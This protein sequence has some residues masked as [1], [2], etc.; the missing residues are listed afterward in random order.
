MKT[1]KI[2]EEVR[3]G[4]TLM[5]VLLV[6]AILGVIAAMAVP[7]LITT[8]GSSNI[9]AAKLSITGIESALNFYHTDHIG[10]FPEGQ[11]QGTLGILTLQEESNGQL[12]GPY[13]E[14]DDLQD[15]WGEYFYYEYPTQKTPNNGLK[16]AIW[17]AGPDRTSGTEDD[18]TNWDILNGQ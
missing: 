18:I 15:P 14:L 10:V 8:L 6:L 16:P 11:D 9:K 2:N 13:L 4:F 17:S 12:K 3:R 5:E 7:Q 1:R